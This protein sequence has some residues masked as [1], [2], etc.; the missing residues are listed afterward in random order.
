LKLPEQVETKHCWLMLSAD[1]KKIVATCDDGL[2][3][4][5]SADLDSVGHI[6]ISQ[7]T[8]PWLRTFQSWHPITHEMTGVDADGKL[9]KIDLLKETAVPLLT[10]QERAVR[11]AQWS[12]D[13]TRLV[14][15]DRDDGSVAIWDVSSGT[16][17]ARLSETR[18]GSARF[19]PD[20][21]RIVTTRGRSDVAP[22]DHFIPPWNRYTR[23]WD[24]E[25]GKL[26]QELPT[27]AVVTFSPDWSFWLEAGAQ[28]VRIARFDGSESSSFS[29]LFDGPGSTCVFSK[30]NR[31]AAYVN[32]SGC[33]VVWEYLDG[34]RFWTKWLTQYETWI[35][36]LA[37]S[38]LIWSVR[39][40]KRKQGESLLHDQIEN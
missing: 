7:N 37:V 4:W 34:A 33:L 14:T 13:G 30:D 17:I 24:A 3:T 16:V 19:S 31:H 38:G 12:P 27:T 21:R 20:G 2:I 8:D 5:D 25:S 1:N 26:I 18:A 40:R 28:G 9:L 22:T 10:K 35:M 29:W 15:V 39:G 36:I 11:G 6:L 32:G 23:I